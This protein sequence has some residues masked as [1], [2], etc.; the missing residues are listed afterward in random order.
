MNLKA[1]EAEMTRAAIF[2][3]AIEIIALIIFFW[4]MYLVTKNAIRDGI[5]ESGLV[6]TW[7]KVVAEKKKEELKRLPDMRA[8]R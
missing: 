7:A 8:E 1:L 5:K 3:T 6:E 4:L 2:S